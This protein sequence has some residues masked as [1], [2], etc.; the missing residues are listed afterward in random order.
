MI[1]F[2]GIF[3]YALYL[4]VRDLVFYSKNNWDFT[5]DSGVPNA[6]ISFAGRK[7]YISKKNSIR[8]AVPILLLILAVIVAFIAR[9]VWA[10][11]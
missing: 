5:L 7:H 2:L 8:F 9:G 1:P 6:W 4:L 11:T 3:I 10:G